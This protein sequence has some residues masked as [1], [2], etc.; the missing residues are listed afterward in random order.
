LTTRTG[1]IACGVLAAVLFAGCGADPEPAGQP[2]TTATPAPAPTV[3]TP[4]PSATPTRTP[5]GTP[6]RSPALGSGL[7]YAERRFRSAGRPLEF[8]TWLQAPK[9]WPFRTTGYGRARAGT[10]PWQLDIEVLPGAANSQEFD[11]NARLAKLRGTPGLRIAGRSPGVLRFEDGVRDYTT[12]TY[13]YRSPDGTR[14]VLSRWLELVG[15]PDLRASHAE[16][17][18]SGRPQDRAGLQ[19][20]LTKATVTL[21]VDE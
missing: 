1:A 7:S 14:L 19:A 12:L 13:T 16:L 10:G 3:T 9:S 8:E 11:L 18:V 4:T 21:T 2:P 17:T 20:V 6:D 15:I 5:T